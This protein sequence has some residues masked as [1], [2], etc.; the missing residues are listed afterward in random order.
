V[1]AIAASALAACHVTYRNSRSDPVTLTM[2]EVMQ[3]LFDLSFDPYACPER[4]W[5]ARGPE[6]ETCAE[7][8]GKAAWYQAQAPL[9]SLNLPVKMPRN[10]TREELAPLEIQPQPPPDFPVNP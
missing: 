2:D 9:R 3:R 10:P 8:P 4:R 1:S 6:L 7:D 5:G